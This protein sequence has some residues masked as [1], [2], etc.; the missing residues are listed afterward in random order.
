MAT[1]KKTTDTKPAPRKRNP[2]AKFAKAQDVEDLKTQVTDGF[3]FLTDLIQKGQTTVVG[4]AATADTA[5]EKEVKKAAPNQVVVNPE[6]D[7]AA[8]E[9][10]GEA[11]DH[12]EEQ[13]LR[14]GGILF[15]IVV[16]KE[17]SNAPEEYMKMFKE[18]RRTKEIG[19]EG[20]GGVEQWCRLVKAN[21][22]RPR[23]FNSKQ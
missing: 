12:C 17:F 22:A 1:T 11:V 13:R 15:T 6:W 8:R 10:I 21:L 18:D 4:G 5:E 16:K 20:F 7:E 19:Q 3:A 14:S 2:P 23:P 9:I